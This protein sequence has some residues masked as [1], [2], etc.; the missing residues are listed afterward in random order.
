MVVDV[1]NQLGYPLVVVGKGLQA[2]EIKA[3]A[4]QNITFMQG[5]SAAE[6]AD[7]YAQCRA[8]I[9]PQ[10]EDYGITPLEAN[11]AG[12][13]VIAY[14]AGGVL[15]TQIPVVEDPSQATALFFDDQTVES[16][17]NA[18]HQFEQIE[19]RFDPQFIREHAVQFDER[20]FIERIQSFVKERYESFSFKHA[21]I[22]PSQS[23]NA[24]R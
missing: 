20:L 4:K 16:L 15:A 22:P 9:F 10:H 19:S 3:Q 21:A 12:R 23:A 24:R 18:I 14:N 8:F 1:F 7:V 5:L 13:P 11:A 6:L 17:T 2:D